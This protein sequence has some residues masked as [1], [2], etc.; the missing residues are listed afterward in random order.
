MYTGPR[1]APSKTFSRISGIRKH[2][3]RTPH[4]IRFPTLADAIGLLPDQLETRRHHVP[5]LGPATID[6][7]PVRKLI[8]TTEVILRKVQFAAL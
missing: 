2:F 1:S 7:L 3:D 4:G 6:K 5:P 8:L